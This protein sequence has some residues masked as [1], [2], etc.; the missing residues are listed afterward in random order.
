MNKIIISLF[1]RN[2]M[3]DFIKEEKLLEKTQEEKDIELLG[4]LVL[5]E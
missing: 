1:W 3:D 5:H 2:F 4:Y